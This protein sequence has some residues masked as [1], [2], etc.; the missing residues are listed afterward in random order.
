MAHSCF[1]AAFCR[2]PAHCQAVRATERAIEATGAACGAPGAI[3]LRVEQ[4]LLDT[5]GLGSQLQGAQLGSLHNSPAD[6]S[7]LL[8]MGRCYFFKEVIF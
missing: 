7:R 1:S 2:S 6:I 5:D 3:G 4:Q 8:G